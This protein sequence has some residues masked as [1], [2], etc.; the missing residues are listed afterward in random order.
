MSTQLIYRRL[1]I[2][3]TPSER[4]QKQMKERTIQAESNWQVIKMTLRETPSLILSNRILL[5]NSKQRVLSFKDFNKRLADLQ[6]LLKKDLLLLQ[7]Y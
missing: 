7:T 2:T 4:F 1:K 5:E 6:F 3:D